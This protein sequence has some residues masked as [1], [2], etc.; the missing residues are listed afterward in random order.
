[1]APDNFARPSGG[2][3]PGCCAG[4][5]TPRGQKLVVRRRCARLGG[6]Q[7]TARGFGF[8]VTDVP[9]TVRLHSDG[10]GWRPCRG[11]REAR[12]RD[13]DLAP[14]E[15][16]DRRPVDRPARTPQFHGDGRLD[17]PA[18]VAHPWRER[19]RWPARRRRHRR[20]GRAGR[21]PPS[22]SNRRRSLACRST[23]S[24][25]SPSTRAR[26]P[27]APRASGRT[28]PSWSRQAPAGQHRRHRRDHD[29]RVVGRHRPVLD[30]HR[31]PRRNRPRVRASS[32]HHFD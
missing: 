18:L 4:R 13:R 3:R 15:R 9:A 17:L 23:S 19:R 21:R 1:M 7:A 16:A 25:P 31:P 24:C 26:T 30:R 2:W 22:R 32:G 20:R 8:V 12:A 6:R 29:G 10:V 11:T 14:L 28:C 5:A 27:R